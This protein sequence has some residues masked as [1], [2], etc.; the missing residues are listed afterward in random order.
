MLGV[1]GEPLQAPG[2]ERQAA[3]LPV[4]TEPLRD[5]NWRLVAQE[6]LPEGLGLSQACGC[7]WRGELR[8]AG[9]WTPLAGE[10]AKPAPAYA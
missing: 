10:A 8:E 7:C 9:C 4:K 2:T 1:L 3:V 6:Q 5:L